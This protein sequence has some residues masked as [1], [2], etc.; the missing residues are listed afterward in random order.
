VAHRLIT[1]ANYDRVV[2]IDNGS[3]AEYD[4]PYALLVENIGDKQITRK[5]GLFEEMVRSTG[6][7]MAKK[8]FDMTK[9]QYEKTEGGKRKAKKLLLDL[10][11]E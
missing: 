7:S 6:S 1:I 10:E 9:E 11:N 8:I 3:V 4:S 5:K 2:V